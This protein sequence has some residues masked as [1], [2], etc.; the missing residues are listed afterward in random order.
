MEHRVGDKVTIQFN[1]A[2][3][4]VLNAWLIPEMMRKRFFILGKTAGIE[5]ALGEYLDGSEHGWNLMFIGL[6]ELMETVKV[7][8]HG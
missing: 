3:E 7:S 6:N 4:R 5:K 1:V 8:Y 2:P